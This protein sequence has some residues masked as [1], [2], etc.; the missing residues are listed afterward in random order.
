VF[1]F[2]KNFE[3]AEA[4]KEK[5]RDIGVN[6]ETIYTAEEYKGAPKS[7]KYQLCLREG[8]FSKRVLIVGENEEDL[9]TA[10]DYI[11][12]FPPCKHWTLTIRSKESKINTGN[13]MIV[14][15][16]KMTG[17]QGVKEEITQVVK[18][19]GGNENDIDYILNR[20]EEKTLGYLP[21][22]DSG[23]A[24][25]YADIIHTGALAPLS[26]EEMISFLGD[27]KKAAEY[28]AKMGDEISKTLVGAWDKAL[29]LWKDKGEQEENELAIEGIYARK[30]QELVGK[31]YMLKLGEEYITDIV[32][33]FG[34]VRNRLNVMVINSLYSKIDR[35]EL[36]TPK[37][38][39]EAIYALMSLL[40]GGP[41]E[42]FNETIASHLE[43]CLDG[44]F[45]DGIFL[46]H[47]EKVFTEYKAALEEKVNEL[48]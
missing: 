1:D 2:I 27:M 22:N 21:S 46:S 28:R 48:K 15:R 3:T 43:K 12:S 18:Q 7:V 16:R 17:T 39:I 14:E 45:S 44:S 36:L 8:I 33:S 29:K 11:N 42:R 41:A 35:C 30:Y 32:Y 24:Q 10:Q 38:R 5:L 40:D 25:E 26:H 23:L 34:P 6:L 20:C 4:F 37:K 19:L 31:D 47:L 9:K 13:Y